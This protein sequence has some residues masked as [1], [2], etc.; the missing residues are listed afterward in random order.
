MTGLNKIIPELAMFMYKLAIVENNWTAARKA[1]FEK[2]LPRQD[3]LKAIEKP[4][5]VVK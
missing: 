2:I 5:P 4:V 1:Y 3:C